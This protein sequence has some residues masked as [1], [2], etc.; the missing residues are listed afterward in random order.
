M[1]T[2]RGYGCE[3]T[4]LIEAHIFPR[5]F[6]RD[7]MGDHKHN[8]LVSKD[9]FRVIQH[10]VYDKNLLCAVCDGALG[11]LD[12]YALD[13]CRRFPREH[14]VLDDFYFM[15]NVDGARF[16][17]F[18]LAVL[19][20]A[21]ISTR[22]EFV[23]TALGP[24]EGIAGEVVF[25]ARPLTDIPAYALI[26]SRFN[27]TNKFDLEQHYTTPA[28]S[29]FGDVNAWGFALHGFHML[30]KIDN[31]PFSADVRPAIVNGKTALEGAF[32]NYAETAE[33]K[34]MLAIAAAHRERKKRRELSR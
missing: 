4:E 14:R 12:K 21:S 18:I 1:P 19:W 10:G 11:D 24:Y 32:L 13:V 3:N 22:P 25:G 2:C 34:A 16:A 8:V 7:M 29:K 20:R 30:A 28:L 9:T 33:G 26:V 5:G 15:P 31:R 27:P 17:R 23:L 6:A